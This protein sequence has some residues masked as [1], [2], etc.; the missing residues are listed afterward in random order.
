MTKIYTC[1]M[2]LAIDL[3]IETEE[4]VKEKVNRT[5]HDEIQ[6]NRKGVNVSLILDQLGIKSTVLGFSG[7][8]TGRYIADFLQQKPI[9]TELIEI[10][11]MTRINVFTK[12]K[13]EQ[14]EY[15]LVN[16]GPL[17]SKVAQTELLEKIAGDILCL[18]GSL[19]QGVSEEILLLISELC[20]KKQVKLIL[21]TSSEVVMQCLANK[22]YLLKPNEQELA[23]WFGKTELSF[24]E[25]VDCAKKLKAR[26]AQNILLSLGKD[27]ALL[28]TQKHCLKAKAPK[29]TV[30]NTA[31]AGDTM[32]G[33]FLG[34]ILQGTDEVEALRKSVAAGSSTAFR[35]GLTDFSDVIELMEQVKIIEVKDHD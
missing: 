20:A 9:K 25:A 27:G 6:A 32:L 30:V 35:R 15:K 21:D 5:L 16:R 4:L 23:T 3:F 7:G 31:G 24:T 17:I 29:G 1:T 19:P 18:S 8:F 11:G 28:L 13:K 12:V 2:N 26:G 33:T 34:E 10:L 22:P 14:T